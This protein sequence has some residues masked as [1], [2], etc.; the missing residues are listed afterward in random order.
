MRDSLRSGGGAAIG[1]G[2]GIVGKI[3]GGILIWAIATIASFWP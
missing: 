2:R 1:R 3:G